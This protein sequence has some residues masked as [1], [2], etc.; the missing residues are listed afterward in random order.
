LTVVDP[1]E[2]ALCGSRVEENARLKKLVASQ[3]LDVQ[4]LK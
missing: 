4:L 3:A 1:A 2:S